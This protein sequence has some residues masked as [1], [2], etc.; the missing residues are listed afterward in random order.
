MTPFAQHSVDEAIRIR[1]RIS[2]LLLDR[3]STGAEETGIFSPDEHDTVLKYCVGAKVKHLL[4]TPAPGTATD[5]FH[6]LHTDLLDSHLSVTPPSVDHHTAQSFNLT[7]PHIDVRS[8]AALPLGL[9]GHGLLP[10]SHHP[11]PLATS[12]SSSTSPNPSDFVATHHHAACSYASCWSASWSLIR[13]WVPLIREENLPS[14]SDLITSTSF[15]IKIQIRD[16]WLKINTASA[17]L[18]LHPERKHLPT[19]HRRPSYYDVILMGRMNLYPGCHLPRKPPQARHP[20]TVH[21]FSFLQIFSTNR[22]INLQRESS[23]LSQL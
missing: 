3:E 20:P 2:E 21:A 16:A 18:K 6:R 17:R 22:T 12:N 5:H 14:L 1:M 11:P 7:S 19:H 15:K 10:F 13:A 8:V 9:G 4:R 23:P